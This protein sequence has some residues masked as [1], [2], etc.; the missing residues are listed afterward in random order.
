MWPRVFRSHAPDDD[1]A[2]G[3][4]MTRIFFDA[5]RHAKEITAASMP[6]RS[7]FQ[8]LLERGANLEHTLGGTTS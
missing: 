1:R 8:W 6:Q 2:V 4:E 5:L 7:W 3:E